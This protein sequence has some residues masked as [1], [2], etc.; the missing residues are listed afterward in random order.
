MAKIYVAAPLG[1]SALADTMA[2]DLRVHGHVITSKWHR[3]ATSWLDP[4]DGHT[5]LL[6]LRSNIVDL[7]AVDCVVACTGEGNPRATY[8]EIG[9]ALARWIPVVWWQGANGEG[10]NIFDAHPA[11]WTVRTSGS[12]LEEIL[13]AVKRVTAFHWDGASSA[14][15]FMRAETP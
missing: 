6:V 2:G 7:L 8:G 5:R 1:Q 3:D 12:A 11:V 14:A 13:G 9:F 15:R 4:A 10:A